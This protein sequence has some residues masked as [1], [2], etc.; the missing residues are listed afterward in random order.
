MEHRTKKN[1]RILTERFGHQIDYV[2]DQLVLRNSFGE[3]K[4]SSPDK[5]ETIVSFDTHEGTNE[6]KVQENEICGLIIEL[7]NRQNI[8]GHWRNP[9]ILRE[10]E[11]AIA[12]RQ[13]LTKCLD[14]IKAKMEKEQLDQFEYGGNM[15]NIEYYKGLVIIRGI[16]S[17]FGTAVIPLD[18]NT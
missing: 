13:E 5:Y 16:T 2:G 12:E 1:I 4:L 6:L 9:G 14:D 7:M 3:I 15:Y 17:G 18:K 10:T 11:F 8:E